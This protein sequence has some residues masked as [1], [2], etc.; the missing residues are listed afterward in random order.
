MVRI[1]NYIIKLS[2]TNEFIKEQLS[3]CKIYE[4]QIKKILLGDCWNYYKENTLEKINADQSK[5][6]G[7][8]NPK[9]IYKNE[10]QIDRSATPN[11]LQVNVL[12]IFKINSFKRESLK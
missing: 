3:K 9:R 11:S 7:G 1:S 12:N 6:L 4:K 10:E 2:D 5:D 8:Q